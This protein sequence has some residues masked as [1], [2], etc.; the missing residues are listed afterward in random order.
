MLPP[1]PTGAIWK[2]T[3]V[4]PPPGVCTVTVIGCSMIC[5]ARLCQIGLG[6]AQLS[7]CS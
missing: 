5:E 2:L 3:L 6:S 7:P 4:A 1:A